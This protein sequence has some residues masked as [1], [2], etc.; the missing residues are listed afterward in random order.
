MQA[1]LCLCRGSL[2]FLCAHFLRLRLGNRFR[3][4]RLEL[5]NAASRV[6]QLLF[7][8]IEG[9]AVRTDFNFDLRLRGANRKRMAAR[10][11]DVRLWEINGVKVFF[12]S[13][14]I[15]DEKS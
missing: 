15:I 13:H 8:G 5:L 1:P 10:A 9:M 7:A 14:V 12:H 3:A 2:C 11:D 4:A 6:D